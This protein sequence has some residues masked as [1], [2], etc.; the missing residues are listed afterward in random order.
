M[1]AKCSIVHRS[2]HGKTIRV[3]IAVEDG[4][5]LYATFTGD[6][7]GEPAEA[8]Q[9]LGDELKG[10]SIA[11]VDEAA[12]KIDEFF[13]EGVFWV[14]GASPDDFKQALVKSIEALRRSRDRHPHPL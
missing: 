12:E 1:I 11:N 4:R 14:A 13:K 9:R 10:L 7:F 6:F 8:L 3:C 2:R 5:I